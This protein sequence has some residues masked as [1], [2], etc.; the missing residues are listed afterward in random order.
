M[1]FRSIAL[2]AAVAAPFVGAAS[3]SAAVPAPLPTAGMPTHQWK[4]PVRNAE[5][6]GVVIAIHG[7]GWLGGD[8]LA[9][10]RFDVLR[11]RQQGWAT[12]NVDYRSGIDSVTDLGR[13]YDI[14]HAAFPSL[15]I[16]ASGQSAGGNLAMM[17][18]AV[19]PDLACAM[20]QEGP[21]TMAPLM[22]G[23]TVPALYSLMH[24]LFRS[25]GDTARMS[26]S[27]RLAG[28]RGRILATYS[29][30]DKIIPGA[31][32]LR[33][34][35]KMP[36][37]TPFRLRGFDAQY[38]TRGATATTVAHVHIDASRRDL[39]AFYAAER[40]LLRAVAGQRQ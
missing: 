6:R 10:E 36:S 4:V 3:A 26:P 23:H 31:E 8:L 25:A 16:C 27:R 2:T 30:A 17:L 24:R 12:L 19:R 40:T 7:G 11:Y 37:V 33:A 34:M 29:M 9:T 32:Q 13:F 21:V 20:S 35:R 18:A 5:P 22:V 15:P 1:N 14:A 39:A 38:G 28:Y